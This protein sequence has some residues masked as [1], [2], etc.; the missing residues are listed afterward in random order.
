VFGDEKETVAVLYTGQV[1]RGAKLDLDLPVL[2][3]EG[4][5]GRTLQ[6]EVDGKVPIPDGLVYVWLDRTKL[7][8]RLDGDTPAMKLWTIGRKEPPQPK[9]PSP[10]LLRYQ[11]DPKVVEA[12]SEGYRVRAGTPGAMPL[13]VRVFNLSE[14]P[15][16]LTLKL[17]FSQPA[18]RVLDP[19]LHSAKVPAR[20]SVDVAWQTDLAEALAGDA[21]LEAT[22]TAADGGSASLASLAIDLL[23]K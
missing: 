9:T 1:D 17:S 16:D 11:F 2:R 14:Q 15:Q 23:A 6:T 7:G 22:V 12:K 19:D 8:D 10:I 3:A 13:V 20:G 4:I 21:R 18:A 5:D